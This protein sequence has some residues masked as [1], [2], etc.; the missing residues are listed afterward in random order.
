MMFVALCVSVAAAQTIY[1]SPFGSPN[2]SGL[3]PSSPLQTL[4][5]AINAIN[6]RNASIVVASGKYRWQQTVSV[7]IESLDISCVSGAPHACQFSAPPMSPC[8]AITASS[9]AP[10]VKMS[11]NNID[12]GGCAVFA[13]VN[14]LLSGDS[15]SLV[16]SG[17][18]VSNV[19]VAFTLFAVP[20]VVS[21]QA[22]G[23]GFVGV[24]QALVIDTNS[25]YGSVQV[26]ALFTDIALDNVTTGVPFF[27]SNGD[28]NAY[29]NVTLARFVVQRSAFGGSFASLANAHATLD[30]IH[31][32]NVSFDSIALLALGAQTTISDVSVDGAVS[33]TGVAAIVAAQDG[34]TVTA[35]RF[36][37]TNTNVAAFNLTGDASFAIANAKFANINVLLQVGGNAT[38]GGAFACIDGQLSL[39][40][41]LIQGCT[42]Q[43]A[44]AG[45]CAAACQ[46]DVQAV[47]ARMNK[48]KSS[49]N[50]CVY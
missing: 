40:S 41:V 16:V 50:E 21:L 33:F 47:S 24:P 44:A 28:S 4:D 13:T 36:S 11:L 14:A 45:Y 15:S 27:E 7:S 32:S 34:S 29:V 1:I 23:V 39:D 9:W 6:S 46:Y 26:S 19:Q 25:Q 10:S 37:V 20:G 42:A 8:L 31:F 3:S 38:L 49:R 2:N 22:S 30:A 17:G 18:T 35:N 43:T 48:E 12:V 5:E